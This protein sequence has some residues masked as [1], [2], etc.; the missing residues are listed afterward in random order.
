[1]MQERKRDPERKDDFVTLLNA[2]L[3]SWDEIKLENKQHEGN[4]FL[5]MKAAYESAGSKIGRL[6]RLFDK[7]TS[8]GDPGISILRK[9]AQEAIQKF[10]YTDNGDKL[11]AFFNTLEDDLINS[12]DWQK[13]WR[14]IQ[15]KYNKEAS[16]EITA[17][18]SSLQKI[19]LSAYAFRVISAA[20]DK[21]FKDLQSVTS[22]PDM[23]LFKERTQFYQ[24][25]ISQ[26]RDSGDKA[27]NSILDYLRV[28]IAQF[29]E[30]HQ[31][32]L[33]FST[34]GPKLFSDINDALL[35]SPPS[36][37]LRMMLEK[38]EN[39]IPPSELNHVARSVKALIQNSDEQMIIK[40]FEDSHIR[41]HITA[42]AK[43]DFEFEKRKAA[44]RA[45][46]LDSERKSK[47]TVS[48]HVRSSSSA[49]FG[50]GA[51]GSPSIPQSFGNPAERLKTNVEILLKGYE[52]GKWMKRDHDDDVGRFAYMF[53]INVKH[54]KQREYYKPKKDETF[55][56]YTYERKMAELEDMLK[57]LLKKYKIPIDQIEDGMSKGVVSSTIREQLDPV[58]LEG[59]HTFFRGL[60]HVLKQEYDGGELKDTS[61]RQFYKM[62]VSYVDQKINRIKQVQEAQDELMRAS[63][64]G[65]SEGPRKRSGS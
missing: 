6:R 43:R 62:L 65:V 26:R 37:A 3:K 48:Q 17:L 59:G 4:P 20:F 7:N 15:L 8:K 31:K 42:A 45:A 51:G 61:Q 29:D 50:P 53:D 60:C 23:S 52:P 16:P 46:D 40:N 21:K 47:V 36:I 63:G 54:V 33:I 11:K 30:D 41:D 13:F 22:Q 58:I 2:C 32:E 64:L 38:M 14:E 57:T 10:D 27:A 1:M 56:D 39:A 25:M 9:N 28:V 44:D 19:I 55:K 49:F 18:I 5:I 35:Y 34:L 12:E 24:A